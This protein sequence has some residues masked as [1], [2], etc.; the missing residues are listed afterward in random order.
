MRR[1]LGRTLSERVID[2][3]SDNVQVS[4]G[5]GRIADYSG[6]RERGADSNSASILPSAFEIEICCLH[7]ISDETL[8]AA[9][10]GLKGIFST[11]SEITQQ[12]PCPTC[13][14]RST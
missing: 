1:L 9:H 5:I 13:P 6:N 12:S 10:P 14:A 11:V 3:V 7:Y 2:S 4:P 8:E